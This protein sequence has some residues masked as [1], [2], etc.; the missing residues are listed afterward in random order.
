[1]LVVE[2]ALSASCYLKSN[3]FARAKSERPNGSQQEV[4]GPRR[5]L[6]DPCHTTPAL[7]EVVRGYRLGFLLGGGRTLTQDTAHL[8]QASSEA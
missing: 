7:C 3:S 4:T 8:I 6:G 5:A 1:M 2:T